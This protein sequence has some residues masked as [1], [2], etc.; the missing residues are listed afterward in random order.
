[1]GLQVRKDVPMCEHSF[2]KIGGPADGVVQPESFPQ[3]VRVLQEARLAGLPLIVIGRGS[4]L[5]FADEGF[6]GIV[7]WVDQK[8]GNIEVAGSRMVVEA[9]AL[10]CRV[11][12]VACRHH[13]AGL[14]HIAGIPGTLGGLIVMNGGSMRRGIGDSLEWVEGCDAKG[15]PFRFDRADCRFR[16]RDSRFLWDPALALF[17]C[18]LS[19]RFGR[20]Y[21]IR[22]AML[23]N[24]KERRRK[25]PR[26]IPNCGS[27]FK[28]SPELHALAG[29][30][31]KIIEDCGFKGK[32]VG[33]AEV[34]RLHANFI[35]NAGQA[36]AVDVL[37]LIRQIRVAVYTRFGFWLETEV[38]CVLPGGHIVP[39]HEVDAAGYPK[40]PFGSST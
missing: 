15:N 4:N 11:A 9:G 34:S 22:R 37:N 32:R 35:V 12:L 26:K 16:Y 40:P 39:A 7:V 3:F 36:R 1:M 30:P 23:A 33:D 38:R 8:L 13:L 24:L 28:S 6:R 2:W 21:E 29:P 25:F 18:S 31:G 5:L 19:L 14:E 17:R 20:R 10:A 27:V